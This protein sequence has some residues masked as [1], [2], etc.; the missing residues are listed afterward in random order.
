MSRSVAVTWTTETGI[1]GYLQGPNRSIEI[2][3][4]CFDGVDHVEEV[5]RDV[6][7][8]RVLLQHRHGTFRWFLS[9]HQVCGLHNQKCGVHSLAVVVTAA[10]SIRHESLRCCLYIVDPQRKTT[11]FRVKCLAWKK[12][13]S[14]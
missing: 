8:A 5:C 12:P 11:L 3:N 1:G 10:W 2:A 4:A 14:P 6:I 13:L 7:L 9:L